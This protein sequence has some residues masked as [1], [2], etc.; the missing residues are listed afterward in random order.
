MGCDHCNHPF[1]FVDTNFN[2]RTRVGCDRPILRAVLKSPHFNPR[3]RVGCDPNTFE[4]I[5]KLGISIHAPAWG[6]TSFFLLSKYSSS[7]SIHAPAWGATD[8]NSRT[9]RIKPISIHAPAWGAT[10]CSILVIFGHKF[11]STH[12]RGV[13]PMRIQISH[14]TFKISIHAPAWGATAILVS[15]GDNMYIISIHAPAWG[16]TSHITFK[17]PMKI[18]QSTHPRGV[19]LIEPKSQNVHLYFNPRTRVG[20][21]SFPSIR[22]KNATII[23]IHAPA[24]GATVLRHPRDIQV[25]ISI[26]APAWGATHPQKSRCICA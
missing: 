19:R 13:R 22:V 8:K 1:K 25:Q 20:C 15:G 16:A 17:K 12:P 2:P 3:T 4:P 6:A 11:Q 10:Y 24:W 9:D 14:I 5:P 26:H 18:F 23:S 21:D 7:I